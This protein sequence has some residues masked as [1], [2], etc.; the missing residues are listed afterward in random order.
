[1]TEP[2]VEVGPGHCKQLWMRRL[3]SS[4]DSLTFDKS[5]KHKRR[6]CGGGCG[7]LLERVSRPSFDPQFN[8]DE[9]QSGQVRKQILVQKHQSSTAPPTG[10]IFFLPN[11]EQFLRPVP[12][13]I[14]TRDQKPQ[15]CTVILAM[16]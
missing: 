16:V 2:T 15:A 14:E 3:A 1:M 5:N 11:L 12:K 8:F 6:C 13:V 9:I 7:W 4:L 10:K